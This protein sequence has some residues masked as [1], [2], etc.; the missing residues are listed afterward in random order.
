MDERDFARFVFKMRTDILYCT[1][2]RE[3]MGEQESKYR[4]YFET[5]D[6]I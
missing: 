4:E 6:H 1:R 5:N 2:P 3:F